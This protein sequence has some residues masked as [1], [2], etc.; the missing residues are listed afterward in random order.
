M[1]KCPGL[2]IR[3]GRRRTS[4]GDSLG[5][6]PCA[7]DR[8]VGSYPFIGEANAMMKSDAAHEG[9]L[10][11][12]SSLRRRRSC[13][14]ARTDGG[15]SATAHREAWQQPPQPRSGDQEAESEAR[16]ALTSAVLLFGLKAA[17]DGP[18]APMARASRGCASRL[19]ERI[20]MGQKVDV[21]ED[22]RIVVEQDDGVF[23]FAVSNRDTTRLRLVA[24]KWE[25]RTSSASS[26]RRRARTSFLASRWRVSLIRCFTLAA[27]TRHS[28][29]TL[30]TA[31]RTDDGV[32][33]AAKS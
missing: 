26:S 27:E 8:K 12:W 7:A 10:C 32:E 19:A 21:T 6:R 33:G 4:D 28:A 31:S 22:G 1:H 15:E 17:D 23:D 18:I 13:Q 9:A 5:S 24:A 20:T 11:R 29:S 2:D 30:V 25:R 3:R 16:V 14:H